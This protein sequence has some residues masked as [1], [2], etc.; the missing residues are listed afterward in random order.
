[1]NYK[2]LELYVWWTCNQ[3]CT[4][5]REFEH[6]EKSWNK[7]VSKYDILKLLIKYKYIG[8][9][10]VTYLWWEPFIQ[11]VFLDS[12]KMWKLF[13]Y[14]ILVTTNATT[15]HIDS[16]ASKFLPYI[17]ELILSVEWITEKLQKKISRTNVL[18][19]WE[20]VFKNIKKYW[21]W[22]YLKVNIVITIDNLKY[23]YSIVEFVIWKWIINI[24]ITYP[25][26]W[27]DY[28][29]KE[30]ILKNIAPI[31]SDIIPSLIKIYKYC[32]LR[33]VNLKIVDIPFCVFPKD[34]ITIWS[35]L[36]D[37]YDYQWRLKIEQWN[38]ED[39]RN[40]IDL[41]RERK[42]IEKCKECI[43]NTICWWPWI[44]YIL[45]YWNLEINNIN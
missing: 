18:V 23:L 28:Y 8:Y 44:E 41:P 35:K 37:D 26:L 2:R 20:Q 17:D 24:S 15:L 16:Q 25:D 45:L 39:Y 7:R 19:H 1:M 43:Y 11:P 9:N 34:M 42:Q 4:Y 32:I 12:L 31:Y 14:T 13:G 3:K 29:S 22:S 6:M 38:K 30:H 40:D 27:S 21:K 33:W 10:H 5:C 36:T